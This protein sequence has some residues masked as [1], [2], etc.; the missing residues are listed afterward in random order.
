MNVVLWIHLLA[1]AV[2][3]GGLITLAALVPAIRKAGADIEVIRAAARQ[4][5]RLSWTA[6]G[7]A[8]VT[9]LMLANDFG[10]SLS[11]SVI[12]TKVRVVGAMIALAGFHQFTAK[13]T[14]PAIR[15]AIQGV[16]LVLAVLTF[17]LAATI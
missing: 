1:V 2:W 12:G 8:V 16:V 15:G 11:G 7:L 9:G 3:T 4:F 14:P 13:K 6:M 10:Y 17:W 5:G